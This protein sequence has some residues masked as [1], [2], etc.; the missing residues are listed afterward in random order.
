MNRL[1]SLTSLRRKACV[2]ETIMLNLLQNTQ[3]QTCVF[4]PSGAD[5][6]RVGTNSPQHPPRTWPLA[7]FSFLWELGFFCSS[8]AGEALTFCLLRPPGQTQISHLSGIPDILS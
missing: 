7:L 3:V 8:R 5:G 1:F 4:V 6:L 2:W